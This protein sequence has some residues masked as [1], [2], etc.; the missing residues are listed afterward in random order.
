MVDRADVRRRTQITVVLLSLTRSGATWRAKR[1]DFVD[2]KQVDFDAGVSRATM[3][4]TGGRLW[5]MER[6]TASCH[7]Q[8]VEVTGPR[9]GLS[10]RSLSASLM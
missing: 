9:K 4:N 10:P 3:G 2:T 5:S 8:L 6:Q 7:Y 1:V